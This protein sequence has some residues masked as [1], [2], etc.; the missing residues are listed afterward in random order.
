VGVGNSETRIVRGSTRWVVVA[1]ILSLGT[2]TAHA[3]QNSKQRVRAFATQPDWTGFWEQDTI[4]LGLGAEPVEGD[5][6]FGAAK[7]W[8]GHPPY[9][10]EWETRYQAPRHSPPQAYC[11]GGFPAIM[12][13]PYAMFEWVVTP[14]QTLMVPIMLKATRQ[15]F[16]DGR[17]HPDKDDLWETPMGDSIGHW[18]GQTLV[19]DTI[20]RKAGPIGKRNELSNQAHFIERIRRIDQ[21]R[22]EDQVTVDDPIAFVHPWQVTLTYKRM[23]GVDRLLPTDCDENDRNPVVNGQF[24]LEPSH[25]EPYVH[26]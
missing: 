6:G 15:I 7:L 10:P 16:T 24:I 18:E 22:M 14:E 19:V 3:D 25:G 8:Q 26:P 9:N 2:L 17:P 5:K 12:D 13:S 1:S 4:P 21:D 23:K 20:G 11:T